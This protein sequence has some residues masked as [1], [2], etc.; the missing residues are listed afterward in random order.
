MAKG[1]GKK[2]GPRMV[3]GI[4]QTARVDAKVFP[5]KVVDA[6]RKRYTGLLRKIYPPWISSEGESLG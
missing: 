1:E 3:D 6:E 2:V 4:D 5:V